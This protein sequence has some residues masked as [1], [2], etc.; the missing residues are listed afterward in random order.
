MN[1]E[2]SSMRRQNLI[3]T[4]T[5]PAI[6]RGAEVVALAI[7]HRRGGPTADDRTAPA[8]ACATRHVGIAPLAATAFPGPRTTVPVAVYV[9]AAAAISIPYL[10]RR[11]IQGA[12]S[13]T[14]HR[15][16]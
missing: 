10:K 3:D 9:V 7:G 16:K 8:M 11:R 1:A 15:S 6:P 4:Q 2:A 13:P 12:A 14:M 5:V